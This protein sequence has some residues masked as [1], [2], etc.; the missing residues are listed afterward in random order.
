MVAKTV[1]AWADHQMIA[2]VLPASYRADL[3]KVRDL[4]GAQEIRL[5]HEAEFATTFPDCAIGTMPPFGNLYGIPVYVEQ[6][7]AAQ[8]KMVFP[9]GTYTETM[10]L[11]Y[12]DFERL[13]HPRV[14]VFASTPSLA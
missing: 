3:G 9:A 4:L 5:A 2:L 8:E 10:S 13:V 12:R 6:H 14:I 11:R 1:I 7:L